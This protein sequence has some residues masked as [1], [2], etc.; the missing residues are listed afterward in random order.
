ML[1]PKVRSSGASVHNIKDSSVGLRVWM[2][3]Q[4]SALFTIA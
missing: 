3:E 1:S 4:Q 2:G